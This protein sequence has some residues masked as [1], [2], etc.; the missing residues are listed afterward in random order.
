MN[1]SKL[2]LVCATLAA[3]AAAPAA[4]A[5]QER[6]AMTNPT[7]NTECGSCHV[8]YPPRL[9]PTASWEALLGDLGNHFGSDASLDPATTAELL[10]YAQMHASA[11]AP[12]A[13]RRCASPAPAGSCTNMARSAQPPGS[14]PRSAARPIAP[15]VIAA[16]TA[17][18]TANV[19]SRFHDRST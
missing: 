3:G 17:A 18:T 16:P 11:R 1:R 7:W 13:N 4:M 9:L 6:F 15:P 2:L 14:G 10:A 12:A 19:A 8:A 5:D